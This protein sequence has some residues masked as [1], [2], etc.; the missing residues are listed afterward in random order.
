MLDDVDAVWILGPNPPQVLAFALLCKL[1]RRRLVLG[2]RQHL[3]RLIRHRYPG[4]RKLSALA[5]A[6]EAAF[7]ALALTTPV[8]V[9]GADLARGYRHA[10]SV[11]VTYVSLLEAD[12]LLPPDPNGRSYD[13]ADLRMLSVGRLD[14]EKNP[15]LLADT[16]AQAVEEDERWSMDICGE[17]TLETELRDRLAALGVSER[18]RFHGYVPIDDGL[19]QLYHDSHAL[20]HISFTEGVPQ[21]LL[22]AFAARL[23]VVATD[24]GGVSDLAADCSL[25]VPAGEAPAAAAALNRIAQDGELRSRLVDRAA[26][27]AAEH[28][29]EAECER[30]A[31]FL[32][33]R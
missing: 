29:I 10:R 32:D 30:L 13:G 16:L 4:Q 24:V 21:V 2:V 17:G 15:L 23:P 28:T 27:E 7:R 1:R 31:A 22:E 3:P 14:P 25:L 6:L 26:E 11:H 20:I 19:W 33:G 5:I 18:V 12:H 8:V 9:V